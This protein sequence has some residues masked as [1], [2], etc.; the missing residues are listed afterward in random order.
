MLRRL[1]ALNVW[2][3]SLVLLVSGALT[4]FAF[5]P[6]RV[7]IIY[8]LSLLVLHVLTA[9]VSPKLSAVRAYLW[10][11][12]SF[13]ACFYWLYFSLHDVAGMSAT[14]AVPL[15]L[16]FAALLALL[17]AV[18]FYWW[19]RLAGGV[20]SP[21]VRDVVLFAACWAAGEWLRTWFLTGFPWGLSAYS[22]VPNA[23]LAS[24]L[25]L[26]GV[27]GASVLLA[28]CVG[29]ASWALRMA[30]SHGHKI[31]AL[32]FFA[33]ILA[34]SFTLK[35]IEWTRPVGSPLSVALIQGNVEQS[36]KWRPESIEPTLNH[37]AKLIETTKA[38]LVLLPETALPLFWHQVPYVWR[39]ERE[40]YLVSRSQEAVMGV[41]IFAQNEAFNG[42][43]SL[44]DP[45]LQ[46]HKNHL[47]PFGEYVPLPW[48]TGWLYQFMDMP[49]LGFARGSSEQLPL[50]LADQKIAFNI[51][52]EDSFGDELIF[53]ARQS[54]M[55]A[56]VS[57]LAWFGD[58]IASA[59][60][61]QLSQ[62]RALEF[63]RPMLRATN[64]GAT[65]V[66]DAKGQVIAQAPEWQVFVLE[67]NI[68]GRE[69]ET[70]YL[71]WGNRPVLLLL[72]AVLFW[73]ELKLRRHRRERA[74][75]L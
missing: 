43:I 72:F 65:A 62:A 6:W 23:P 11:F 22:Q 42:V 9:N 64:T 1:E 17:P 63:A 31:A 12:A 57:N 18:S 74:A 24:W 44:R 25:P 75:R 7:W 51:C 68:S 55:L 4:V 54:T 21:F 50:A 3:R 15:L 46:Y 48:L 71:R 58:S 29:V 14:L 73:G 41:P 56:N 5:A 19:R 53:A 26:F 34:A 20:A 70:P 32:S 66:I 37:Y 2:Q 10:S 40:R 36:L 16:S 47:V 13:S 52:Y 60:H 8:L 61:L 27:L 49:M 30:S 45:S 69:G 38:R 28:A 39:A 35:N 67:A 59:Q 33:V